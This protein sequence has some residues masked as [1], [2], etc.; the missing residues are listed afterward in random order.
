MAAT[1][2][3]L[4][5]TREQY[6]DVK[7]R[8]ANEEEGADVQVQRDQGRRGRLQARARVVQGPRCSWR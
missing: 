4:T 7:A 1:L 2:G 3:E 5:G 6:S 8:E